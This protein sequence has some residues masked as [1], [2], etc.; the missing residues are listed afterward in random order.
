[1]LGEYIGRIYMET[2]NRPRYILR[3]SAPKKINS[4]QNTD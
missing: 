2:K 4:P 1:V 3:K